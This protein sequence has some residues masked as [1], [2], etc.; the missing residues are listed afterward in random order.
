M[1]CCGSRWGG[2]WGVESSDYANRVE[3]VL[4]HQWKEETT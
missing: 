2:H 3:V 4:A 1:G